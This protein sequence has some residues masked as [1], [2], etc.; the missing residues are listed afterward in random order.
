M[1]QIDILIMNNQVV[2]T[3]LT[4]LLVYVT[5]LLLYA[6]VFPSLQMISR[7]LDRFMQI[8]LIILRSLFKTYRYDR[9][10][11]KG[12]NVEGVRKETIK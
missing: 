7:K 10:S 9:M 4:S 8:K 6:S 12:K 5:V 3:T 11:S 1:P 2:C